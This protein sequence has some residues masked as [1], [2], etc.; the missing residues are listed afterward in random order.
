M[1]LFLW[2]SGRDEHDEAVEESQVEAWDTESLGLGSLDAASVKQL[3]G[4]ARCLIRSKPE[5]IALDVPAQR[6][7]ASM[8]VHWLSLPTKICM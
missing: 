7:L 4:L 5:E 8:Q 6:L 1:N 2:C 3:I